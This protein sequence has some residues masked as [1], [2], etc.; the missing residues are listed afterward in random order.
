M[1]KDGL[2]ETTVMGGGVHV[3]ELV[4]VTCVF[5]AE[6]HPK[7]TALAWVLPEA[8]WRWP[9]PTERWHPTGPLTMGR[10]SGLFDQQNA[11]TAGRG[12]SSCLGQTP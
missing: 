10:P 12:C 8:D 11:L 7:G 6:V 3:T 2:Y 1:H 5:S 9:P 4:T